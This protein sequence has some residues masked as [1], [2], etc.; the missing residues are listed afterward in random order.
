ME[1]MQPRAASTRAAVLRAAATVFERRG[2]AASTIA[3]ILAEGGVTK[4]AAYFHF[5]SKEELARAIVGEQTTW[6]GPQTLPGPGSLQHIV[7]LSYRFAEALTTD[8]LVRASIR[9]TLERNTFDKHPAEPDPYQAWI[10]DLYPHMKAAEQRDEL[11]IT[12]ESAAHLI[13]SAIT[14]TQL[15]SEALTNRTDLTVRIHTLWATLAPGMLTT[16]TRHHTDLRPPHER[17]PTPASSD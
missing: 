8:V 13:V 1:L 14:G 11:L 6:R 17:Q 12:P 10:D 16:D 15:V 5:S 7:D 9:L 4:G 2:Y 3:E